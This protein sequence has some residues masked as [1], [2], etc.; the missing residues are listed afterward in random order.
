MAID[1]HLH[2]SSL[3]DTL[4]AREETA[5][6]IARHVKIGTYI[7]D[8]CIIAATPAA[9]AWYSVA[10]PALLIGQWISVIH[11]PDDARLGRLL[12]VARHYGHRVPTAYV[13]RIRQGNTHRFRP[14]MKQT[15]QLECDGERYWITRLSEPQ[16]PPLALQ[17]HIWQDLQL[18]DPDKAIAYYGKASVADMERTL[19]LVEAPG[20]PPEGGNTLLRSTGASPTHQLLRTPRTALATL[21]TLGPYLQHA[22]QAHGLSQQAL[23]QRCT[24][25]LGQHVTRKYVSSLECGYCLPSLPLFQVLAMVLDL[26]LA[27]V[28]STRLETTDATSDALSPELRARGPRDQG[29]QDLLTRV[30]QAAHHL[31]EVQQAHH[32]ALV[33]ARQAGASWRQLAA[34]ARLSS[35]RIRQLLGRTRG[36]AE[37]TSPMRR[38]PS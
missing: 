38:H 33:A 18:V 10:D 9:A 16:E 6:T 28:L 35:S 5:M 11:H 31:A 15:S 19:D 1:A 7:G 12:S 24:Q 26:D 27:A 21:P 14:V 25:L 3:W 23:A 29:P 13:S 4:L 8:A 2:L 22:R 34:A 17:Q 37:P 30:E 32:E 36:L 20:E